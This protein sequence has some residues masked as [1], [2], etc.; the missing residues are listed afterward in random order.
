M[1]QVQ[2]IDLSQTYKPEPTGVQ[3]FFSKL[4]KTYKDEEDR[5]HIGELI[6]K[7]QKNREDANAWEDL[8][9]SLERSNISPTKRLETQK[10]LNEMRK[11][12]TE[13]DKSLNKNVTAKKD[14]FD[15]ELQKRGAAEVM[16]LE[17]KIPTYNNTLADI[18]EME[19]LSNE[20]L[21]GVKGYIKG[22]LNTQASRELDT[23]GAS[24]L[25]PI[26]KKFN[27]AGTLPTAKLN[28]IRK[29]FSP[30]AAEN[31]S[32]RQGKINNLRRFTKQAK[33]KDEERLRLLKEYRGIIPAEVVR[34]FDAAEY[35]ENEALADELSFEDKI[36][37][38]EPND[39]VEGMYDQ[40]G[41]K[42]GPIPKKEAVKLFEQGLITN[43]PK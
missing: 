21:G 36:R 34:Q 25:D 18:D 19:R 24:S 13:R 40:K 23:L 31:P 26:I 27:P 9:L 2:G 11:L 8:Q 3:E 42:L 38:I 16:E 20:Y 1:P 39:L 12:I 35:A 4:N 5:I 37:D 30:S 17:K 28:W 41:E 33:K 10:S 29:T 22:T 32:G 43:V 6:D 15:T 14:A 7:Y